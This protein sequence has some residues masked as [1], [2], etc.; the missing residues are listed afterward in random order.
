MTAGIDLAR[1]HRFVL[2]L[3]DSHLPDGSGVDGCK[4]IRQFDAITP[5]V[6]CSAAAYE[7]DHRLAFEAGAQAYFDKPIDFDGLLE[8]VETLI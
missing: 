8:V 6:F 1:K 5:I 7:R 2:Y 4:S 3:L